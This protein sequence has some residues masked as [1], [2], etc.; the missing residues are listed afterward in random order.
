MKRRDDLIDKFEKETGA[1]DE[2]N[3]ATAATQAE[4]DRVRKEIEARE[5]GFQIKALQAKID[6]IRSSKDTGYGVSS[7]AQEAIASLNKQIEQIKG[8]TEKGGGI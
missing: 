1:Q 7:D 8:Q 4:Q 3:E 5:P 6:Q 2:K